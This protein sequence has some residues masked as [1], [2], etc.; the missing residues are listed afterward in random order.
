MSDL[1]A[2]IGKLSIPSL[3]TPLELSGDWVIVGDV[4]VPYSDWQMC[5]RVVQVGRRE[6][7]RNLLVAG[8]FWDYSHWSMYADAIEPASWQTERAAGKRLAQ[9]W[10]EWFTDIRFLTGNHERRRSKSTEG[11]EDDEDIFSPLA[12]VCKNMRSS[13]YGWCELHSGGE[14][15]R[16]THPASYRQTPLSV[17]NELAQ[18][19][20]THIIGWHEH[21][22]GMTFSKY[23]RY[24]IVNGG[25]LVDA[26][27]LAYVTLD[28]NIKPTMKKG[29]CLVKGGY[30]QLFGEPPYTD[31]GKYGSPASAGRRDNSAG[32]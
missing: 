2:E 29:F 5:E 16:V 27:K 19:F 18:K 13:L 20:H 14:T 11:A 25:S 32:K 10:G 31:W 21:M 15:Y 8:D 12:S 3:P 30:C 1:L 17:V 26:C 7:I 24:L 9:S 22:F 4:H 28:D 23:G 6:K